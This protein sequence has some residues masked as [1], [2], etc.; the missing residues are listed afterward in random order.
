MVTLNSHCRALA[1]SGVRLH[2][3][4]HMLSRCPSHM[5]TL[6]HA[7]GSNAQWWAKQRWR[8]SVRQLLT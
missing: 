8:R 2:H 4:A 7:S 3:A 6:I 1:H 5:H